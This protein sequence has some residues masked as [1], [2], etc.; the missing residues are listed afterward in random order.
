VL[1]VEKEPYLCTGYY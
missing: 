1:F